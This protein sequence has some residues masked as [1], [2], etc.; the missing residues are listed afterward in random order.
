MQVLNLKGLIVLSVADLIAIPDFGAGAMENW[1]LITYRE[2]SLL[3]SDEETSADAK[4]WIAIVV[5]HEL[6]R[7]TGRG[8]GI[9]CILKQDIIPVILILMSDQNKLIFPNPVLYSSI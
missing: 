2:T 6:V 5:A 4:Q 8:S 9:G 1:G 7:A 3:Y